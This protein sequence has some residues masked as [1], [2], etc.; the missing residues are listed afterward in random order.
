MALYFGAYLD[1][2]LANF[3]ESNYSR[4]CSHTVSVVT[5]Q[6]FLRYHKN[7]LGKYPGGWASCLGETVSVGWGDTSADDVRFVSNE[8]LSWI[9]RI[10]IRKPGDLTAQCWGCRTEGYLPASCQPVSQ[11]MLLFALHA[12][13]PNK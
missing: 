9:S 8:D 11:P 1:Q 2:S 3:L 7:G 12:L 13:P 4:T 6:L 5:M 10:Q